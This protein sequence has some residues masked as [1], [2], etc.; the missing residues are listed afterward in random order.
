MKIEFLTLFVKVVAKNRYFGN[1]SIFQQQLF[2]I[3]G[4]G[5]GA[6]TFP[7][8]PQPQV[9]NIPIFNRMLND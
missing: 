7:M 4:E 6:G 9:H 5:E 3:S 8:L 1:N 2:S